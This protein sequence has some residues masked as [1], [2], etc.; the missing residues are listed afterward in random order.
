M[1]SAL[2]LLEIQETRMGGKRQMISHKRLV[3]SLAVFLIM[4]IGTHCFGAAASLPKVTLKLAHTCADNHPYNVGAKKLADLVSAKT[5]GRLKI[6]V[7]PAGQLGG[8]RDIVEALQAGTIDMCVTSLGVA[9]TF[10]P[11]YNLFNLPFLFSGADHFIAVARGPIG[12]RLLAAADS[13]DLKGLGF[14]GPVFRVPMN[15]RRALNTP[16]DFKGL[17]IRLMEVPVHM[18]TYRALGASPVPI[19]FGELY[20]ALQLGTVDGCEN[21]IATLYTQ[22]FYEVQKYLS[23]LPVIS[24]GAV[25]LSGQKAWS[26]LPQE[27]R[28]IIMESMPEAIAAHDDSYL[29]LDKEGLQAIIAKGVHVNTPKDLAPFVKAT[30]SVY[31]SNLKKMPAWVSELVPQIRA[32]AQ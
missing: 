30:E 1:V 4:S 5:E 12:A 16:E 29:L 9:A 15:S 31:A 26:R 25:F 28:D 19:A 22:R 13:H 7:Y 20:T 14:G 24:N 3:I 6:T 18:D 27:Y 23:V 21:A 32:L 10:V 11:E 17:K 8:E 2:T